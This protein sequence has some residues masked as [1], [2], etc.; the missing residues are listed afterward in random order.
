LKGLLKN[1]ERSNSGL[2]DFPFQIQDFAAGAGMDLLD[3]VK[4]DEKG[5][6]TA[7]AQDADTN[8][9]LMVAHMNRDT[10]QETL[11]TGKMVYWSRSRRQ[12]WLKGETSGHFQQVHDAY[13]DCDGDA[14]LF[15]VRQEGGA[16]HEGY[17]SCFFRKRSERGWEITGTKI[18]E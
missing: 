1:W 2:F 5:L 17:L 14:L 9:V 10:L 8:Q 12:R 15:K 18:E 3:A 6:V 13:I 7:I 16:C 4:F 11:A